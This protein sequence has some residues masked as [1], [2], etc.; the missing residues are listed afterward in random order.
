MKKIS[1]I[2]FFIFFLSGSFISKTEALD[3]VP[4]I[5]DGNYTFLETVNGVSSNVNYL[6]NWSYTNYSECNAARINYQNSK[7]PTPTLTVCS[8][9]SLQKALDNIVYVSPQNAPGSAVSNVYNFLAPI[10][11]GTSINTTDIG[12]YFN[13]IFKLAIGLCAALA[14]IMIIIASVQYMGDESIFGKTEAKD[15]ILKA[16][17]GLLIAVGSWVLLNTINP[18]L[19]GVNG[20]NVANVTTVVPLYDRGANDPKNANGES[21][22]CTPLTSGPCSVANLT[23]ALG[24]NT[25]TATAMSKI[26][27]MESGGTSASSSTDYCVPP[28]KSL[29]FSF[30]LFQVN[31]SS[32][33]ILAGSD[34]VGLFNKAVTGGDAIEPKYNNGFSCSLTATQAL[35]N[36]CKNRL[37]DSTKNLAIAK[38]LLIAHPDKSSWKGDKKYCASAFN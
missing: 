13:W 36:T 27:N 3:I 32:N 29:P 21:I 25:T 24:V 10:G 19:T 15:K 8:Q 26:C 31:L 9:P 1:L 2:I 14:V 12:V 17:L 11:L 18:A 22:R 33:G 6:G 34:C 5:P 4:T 38:S 37:L 20:V 23:T 30:G 28:G 16:I 35:Y 7:Q